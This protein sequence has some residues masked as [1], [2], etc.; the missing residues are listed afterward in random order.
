ELSSLAGP[1]EGPIWAVVLGLLGLAGAFANG[2]VL[3]VFARTAALRNRSNRLVMNLLSINLLSCFLL[4]TLGALDLL[5]PSAISGAVGESSAAG[6]LASSAI[7]VLCVAADQYRAVLRPLTYHGF[8]PMH[9]ALAS[10]FAGV[11]AASGALPGLSEETSLWKLEGF[12][13]PPRLFRHYFAI[14][15][16][17]LFFIIPVLTLMFLYGCIY[18]EAHRNSKR[19][20]RHVDPS[21]PIS[22]PLL[23]QSTSK[24]RLVSSLKHRISNASLFSILNFR[25]REEAR[26]A[27]ISFLVVFTCVV[28]W[29][30]YCALLLLRT[31]L[32]LSIPPPALAASLALL[33]C[34]SLVSPALFAFRSRR[35]Q[36]EVARMLLC[37]GPQ[38]YGGWRREITASLAPSCKAADVE[39]PPD[40]SRSSFSSGTS[41]QGTSELE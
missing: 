41:T 1:Y 9:A 6:I 22:P 24:P 10:W 29:A 3:L 38:S 26:A 31:Q 32:G 17:S 34:T 4:P 12:S 2:A 25:Y 11:V 36:R 18:A 20:R 27:R 7:G 16:V 15:F 19:A 21:T 28:C 8:R 33:S 5:R 40:T 37:R 39:S 30:P 35:L 14:A 23:P 13:L